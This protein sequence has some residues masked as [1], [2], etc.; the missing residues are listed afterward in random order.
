MILFLLNFVTVYH[1]FGQV[2]GVYGTAAP[3]AEIFMYKPMINIDGGEEVTEASKESG[4]VTLRNIRFSYPTKSKINVISDA[5]ITVEKNKTVAIV[6]S[7]G[8]G[9]STIIN[10]IERFYDPTAGTI[11]YGE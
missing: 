9:K 2:F 4:C 6:G 10:L 7:S 11:N 5:S 8:C 3:I 1:C